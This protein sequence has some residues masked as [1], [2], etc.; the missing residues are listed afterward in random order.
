M[1]KGHFSENYLEIITKPFYKIDT[2]LDKE[3]FKSILEEIQKNRHL[4]KYH[5]LVFKDNSIGKKY[6]IDDNEKFLGVEKTLCSHDKNDHGMIYFSMESLKCKNL[7]TEENLERKEKLLFFYIISHKKHDIEK[8]VIENFNLYEHFKKDIDY[9]VEIIEKTAKDKLFDREKEFLN[10]KK[11]LVMKNNEISFETICKFF[12][13]QR[14]I[15]SEGFDYKKNTFKV[16]IN[17]K[18]RSAY[19]YVFF[20]DN[21]FRIEQLWEAEESP[22]PSLPVIDKERT[23]SF[24][25]FN[26]QYNLKQIIFDKHTISQ[27]NYD[28]I[29]Q[30][31]KEYG[32]ITEDD[33]ELL[34]MNLD[35][36]LNR[37]GK[38]ININVNSKYLLENLIYFK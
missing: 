18:K 13:N 1:I 22:D 20:T 32:N 30:H 33:A 7:F 6:I 38:H 8:L 17:N 29:Y 34:L 10:I 31:L 25:G 14:K 11:S 15:F 2:S 26:G 12:L 24:Y 27:E 28:F 35:F 21:Q 5:I 4:E 23:F 9:A 36:D 16:F 37:I 19:L 3:K